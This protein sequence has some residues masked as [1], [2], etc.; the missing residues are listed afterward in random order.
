MLLHVERVL[1]LSAVIVTTVSIDVLAGNNGVA[2]MATPTSARH[3]GNSPVISASPSERGCLRGQ[4]QPRRLTPV[5]ERKMSYPGCDPEGHV[6]L[7]P[8]CKGGRAFVSNRIGVAYAVG[9]PRRRTVQQ[10][11]PTA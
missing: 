9:R 2:G 8:G 4:N 5:L 11:A 6:R 7:P 3:E 10:K 1:A